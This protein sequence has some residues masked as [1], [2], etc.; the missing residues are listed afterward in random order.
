[1]NNISKLLDVAYNIALETLN[2]VECN[3]RWLP[4]ET[5][6]CFYYEDELFQIEMYDD[7]GVTCQGYSMLYYRQIPKYIVIQ[8]AEYHL[9][10]R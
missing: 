2:N 1:M 9:S 5:P 10:Q 8:I 3:G 7:R 4:I 6:L